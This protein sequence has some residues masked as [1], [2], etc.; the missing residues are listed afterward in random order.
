MANIMNVEKGY[1]NNTGVDYFNLQAGEKS[2]IYGFVQNLSQY[3]ELT[4]AGDANQF[5]E[6]VADTATLTG[7]AIVGTM[8][9]GNNAVLLRNAGINTANQIPA[10]P[11]LDPIPV[12]VPVN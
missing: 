1:Q 5:L 8:R 6:N 10:D 4:A 11:P 7:Q 3:A 2:S 9:E 12:V